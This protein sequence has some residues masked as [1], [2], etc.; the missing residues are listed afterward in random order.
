MKLL[1]EL[2]ICDNTRLNLVKG[3]TIFY[4]VTKLIGVVT[5]LTDIEMQIT[6]TNYDPDNN[7]ST[8][9][10]KKMDDLPRAKAL[11]DECFLCE[12]EKDILILTIKYGLY[13]FR[14][15]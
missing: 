4:R 12:D 11:L 2:L 5:K 6:W 9:F 15:N 8:Y 7:Q 10:W 13:E 14:E 3:Q 1:R